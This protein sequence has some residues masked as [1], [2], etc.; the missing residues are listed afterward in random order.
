MIKNNRPYSIENG[1][2]DDGLITSHSKEE[3]ETVN[4]WIDENI[5]PNKKILRG[6]TSYGMKHILTHDTGIYLTNNEFKDALLLKGYKPVDPNELN[7]RYRII[8]KKSLNDNPSPFLKWA[9]QY[10]DDDSPEGDFVND[11]LRDMNFPKEANRRSI[12][13]YLGRVDACSEAIR[14]FNNL[15]RLYARKTN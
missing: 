11:M 2:I 6:R 7:W 9:K 3:I 15:W 1:Y 8:L 13:M 5:A 14:A 4:K 12:L 10:K